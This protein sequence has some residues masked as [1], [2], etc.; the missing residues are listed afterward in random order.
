[1]LAYGRERVCVS[2]EKRYRCGKQEMRV[3]EQKE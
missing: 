2:F 3:K 1:M